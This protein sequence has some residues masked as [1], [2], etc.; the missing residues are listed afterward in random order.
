VLHA[1]TDGE[2]T[3]GWSLDLPY[4]LAVAFWAAALEVL[5]GRGLPVLV[6]QFSPRGSVAAVLAPVRGAGIFVGYFSWLLCL[7]L[8]AYVLA[9]VI[10]RRGFLAW[11]RKI[12]T[13]LFGVS[14]L[15][16]VGLLGVLPV[17]NPEAE[18]G[19]IVGLIV[20]AQASITALTLLVGFSVLGLRTGWIKKLFA[21]FPVLILIVVGFHQFFYFYP[22]TTPGWLPSGAA[23]LALV[24]GQFLALAFP[25]PVAVYI[26]YQHLRHGLPVFIHVLVAISGFFPCLVLANMPSPLY[27]DVFY[28]MLGMQASLPAPGILYPLVM[29]P[30]LFVFSALVGTPVASRAFMISRRRAGF[31]LALVYLGSFTPLTAPQA[32]FLL[33]GLVLWMKS[34]VID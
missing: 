24:L 11:W 29:L 31:G 17:L 14:A 12:S 26:A 13:S 6:T 32:A 7:A 4:T 25:F 9:A 2:R 16:T 33:L 30:M 21:T 10:S 28:A 27:R 15:S 5:L 34:I 19:R 3:D 22:L 18:P 8:G 1:A 20:M 23:D